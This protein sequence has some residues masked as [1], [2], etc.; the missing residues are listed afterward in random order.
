LWV[1]IHAG[2]ETVAVDTLVLEVTVD[3]GAGDELIRWST[4]PLADADIE[5]RLAGQPE[6]MVEAGL[7]LW[8]NKTSS[9]TGD[10]ELINADGGLDWMIDAAVRDKPARLLVGNEGD[11]LASFT[12]VADLVVD[13]IGSG[14]LSRLRVKFVA[15][16][17]ALA[18]SLQSDFYTDAAP[19]P[20]LEGRPVPLG[21]GQVY[22]APAV[23]VDDAPIDYDL[24]VVTPAVIQQV[25]SN[26]NPALSSQWSYRERGFRFNITPAGK[27]TADFAAVQKQS[28]FTTG[29]FP[30]AYPSGHLNSAQN[31]DFTSWTGSSP[32]QK[33]VGW[34]L[35]NDTGGSPTKLI[36]RY[37]TTS[38]LEVINDDTGFSGIA[39]TA[40]RL[41]RNIGLVPGKWYGLRLE[42]LTVAGWTNSLGF[43]GVGTNVAGTE[44]TGGTIALP[45][46]PSSDF[47]AQAIGPVPNSQVVYFR[48]AGPVL[49]VFFGGGIFTAIDTEIRVNYLRVYDVVAAQTS[50]EVIIPYVLGVAGWTG[51]I[52]QAELDALSTA[53]GPH[54]LGDWFAG[55]VSVDAVL[56]RL[57]APFCAWYYV[58]A[59][60]TMRFGRLID[61]A[62]IPGSPVLNITEQMILAGTSPQITDDLMPGLSD[63]YG[64]QRNH[65]P[66][67]QEVAAGAVADLQERERI[68]ADFRII[69]RG[70]GTDLD[71]FYS[72]AHDRCVV[73]TTLQDAVSIPRERDRTTAL[74][75]K[76]RQWCTL[77]ALVPEQIDLQPGQKIRVTW[78]GKGLDAGADFVLISRGRQHLGNRL[79]LKLWR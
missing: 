2:A 71:P 37:L 7:W 14:Q 13:Y 24:N 58:D 22:Q 27:I 50:L 25:A 9:G 68:A 64:G 61:P 48:A 60:G 67:S 43:L 39:L 28:G 36:R 63:T 17:I 12:E 32:N 6:Y 16:D 74:A 8:Q 45:G 34:T 49:K 57:L 3:R 77:T 51:G 30:A 56:T 47:T 66:I 15:P 46:Y 54:V 19:I 76:R 59:A 42:R 73:P 75:G 29:D 72:W 20:A 40:P 78:P 35:A 44:S 23:L 70:D 5:V 21:L 69:A 33:P 18:A 65:H 55:R 4:R 31:S 79:T 38:S 26:G 10:A 62:D 11:F 1:Q 41:C 52:N 53:I